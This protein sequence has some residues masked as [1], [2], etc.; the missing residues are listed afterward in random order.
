[1]NL[2]ELE[3]AHTCRNA[4]AMLNEAMRRESELVKFYEHILS[5]CDYPEVNSFLREMTEARGETILRIVQKLNELRAKSQIL[6]GVMS[7]YDPAGC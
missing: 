4:C 6:D 5:Q 7:S 3:C 1:M 2:E